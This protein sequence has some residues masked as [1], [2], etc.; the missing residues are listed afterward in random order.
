MGKL[1]K[2]FSSTEKEGKTKSKECDEPKG[3]QNGRFQGKI[4]EFEIACWSTLLRKGNI[5]ALKQYYVLH[6]SI[7]LC[8][9]LV[10]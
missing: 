4:P 5:T 10:E 7:Q 6:D 8:L 9:T 3:F 1:S 2:G